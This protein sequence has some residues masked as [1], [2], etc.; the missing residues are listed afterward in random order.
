MHHGV[1]YCPCLS[2]RN[3]EIGIL[4]YVRRITFSIYGRRNGTTILSGYDVGAS[5]IKIHTKLYAPNLGGSFIIEL[6]EKNS[7]NAPANLDVALLQCTDAENE[8]RITAHP[9]T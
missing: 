6:I 5:V 9:S 3:N 1:F 7:T 4:L 2:P 8:V